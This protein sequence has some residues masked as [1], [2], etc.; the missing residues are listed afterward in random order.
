MLRPSPVFSRLLT[1]LKNDPC[2][3]SLAIGPKSAVDWSCPFSDRASRRTKRLRGVETGP[4]ALPT[5]GRLLNVFA[6]WHCQIS[7]ACALGS[8]QVA[9]HFR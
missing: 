3:R 4:S 2:R 6:E 5:L 1:A 9:M 8:R 7:F